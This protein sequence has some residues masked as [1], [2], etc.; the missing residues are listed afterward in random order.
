MEVGAKA[1]NYRNNPHWQIDKT[2]EYRLNKLPVSGE[3]KKYPWT[4]NYWPHMD[5]GI[6]YRWNLKGVKDSHKYWDYPLHDMKNMTGVDLN[7]LSPAEKY[8]LY[9]G[10]VNWDTVKSER[11]YSKINT[12]MKSSPKYDPRYKI[13][14]WAGICNAWS[15]SAITF[16]N[17]KPVLMT[18]KLG[19]RIPFGASDIKGLLASM[20]DM[21]KMSPEKTIGERCFDDLNALW[22]QVQK[23]TLSE[24]E[25]YGV[26]E[27]GACGDVNA[28]A[29]HV[30][31]TNQIALRGQ[32]FMIDVDRGSQ[33]WNQP[34]FG[35]DIIN[36]EQL[37]EKTHDRAAKGTEKVVF[38]HLKL[39]YIKEIHQHWYSEIPHKGWGTKDYEYLLEL[40]KDENII[41]GTWSS[42]ERPDYVWLRNSRKWKGPYAPLKKIYTDSTMQGGPG[43]NNRPYVHGEKAKWPD[44]ARY[45]KWAK[46][47]P[48][49]RKF[50][51][52]NVTLLKK[53]KKMTFKKGPNPLK[54]M[55]YKGK[56]P[57]PIKEDLK[58]LK[59]VEQGNFSKVKKMIDKGARINVVT[60]DKRNALLIASTKRDDRMVKLLLDNGGEFSIDFQNAQGLSPLMA[61]LNSKGKPNNKL[62]KIVKELI[63]A[64]PALDLK[65]NQGRN[66]LFYAEKYRDHPLGNNM[67]KMIQSYKRIWD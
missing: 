29:F 30:V 11:D 46:R 63:N 38:V 8:D 58:F 3:L 41:G 10:N 20:L 64:G 28:G 42:Y 57:N 34:V 15:E 62:L 33:V 45:K 59:A 19:H 9:L 35:Y 66:V 50:D 55:Y 23:G 36:M 40:D 2:Y 14:D 47:A 51:W 53:W 27:R 61:A 1:W 52:P 16:E 44:I 25:F 24:D 21:D 31:L 54:L 13:D 65:D 67:Y 7:T 48:P 60:K 43:I 17:P 32:G 49:K 18:G 26:S 37:P 56:W 39:H 22:A 12:Q 6:T 4:G 5:G